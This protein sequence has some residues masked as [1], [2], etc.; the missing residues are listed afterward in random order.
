[1]PDP[2]NQPSLIY[3]TSV[4]RD[5]NGNATQ[6]TQANNVV[7]DYVFDALDRMTSFST[8]PDAQTTL[9]TSFVLDGAGQPL[10]RTGA[11][12]VTVTYAYDGIS[13]LT[14]VSA[15]GLTT[16][17]YQYDQLSHRTQMVDGTGTTNYQY[18]GLGRLTQAAGA[19]GT[20]N[21]GYDRD[22]NPTSLQYPTTK[23][24]N[25]FFTPGGRLDHLIDWASRTSTYVYRPSGLVDTVTLP[26][27]MRTVYGY[28][29]AQRL[30]F[31]VSAVGATTLN[32]QVYALD[33][34]GNRTSLDEYVQGITAVPTTT[35]AASVKVNSDAGTTVQDHPAIAIGFEA[36]AAAT[37]LV[38]DDARN[39]NADIFFSRRD[40]TTG[41]WGTNVKV[42][43]DSGTRGQT[44]PAISL[45]TSN[46]AYA[47]WQDDRDGHADIY[48]ASLASG[49]SAWSANAK[50]S[51]D[52]ATAAQR[53]PRVGIDGT[54][55]LIVA[56]LD[57][58]ATPSQIRMSRRPA[59]SSAWSASIQVTDAAARPLSAALAVRF[60]GKAYLTF[61]DNRGTSTDVYGTEYDPWLNSWSTSTLVSDDP[62]SA[63][64][65]SPTVAY[66]SGEIVA[67]WRDDRAGN[68]NVQ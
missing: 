68:A 24:V 60:D 16:I 30:T 62:G 31:D 53:S 52:P 49:G 55:T 46:N 32:R 3:T 9:T 42:N 37:Y 8:H 20:L 5:D 56:W 25:Y 61:H 14:S 67:S 12:S 51:D 21:Y 34:E 58:R 43:T 13:R 35:W 22:G 4:T 41:I 18:D 44:N 11:D 39:S 57:D 40:P 7:T 1:K 26:N 48:F 47:A 65:Q 59:G 63:N 28:D 66:T 29:R 6:V 17:T 23:S 36:P 19:N 27:G 50:I 33:K 45:D 10:S 54:G 64:Q 38:W 15:T 2:L